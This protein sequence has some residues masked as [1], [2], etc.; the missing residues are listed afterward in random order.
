[1]KR[2]AQIV[3]RFLVG[4]LIGYVAFCVFA[5]LFPQYFYYHPLNERPSVEQARR[6]G[7]PAG[8]VEYSAADGT[9]LYGWM[10][11]P[12]SRKKMIIFLHGNSHNIGSFYYK[13]QPLAQ[14]GYGTFLPEFRGFGGINGALREA[15][16]AKDAIAAIEY[17]NKQGY[18]NSDIIVYGMSLG[19]YLASNSVYQLQKNGEFAALILEVPFD[20]L[21]NTAKAVVPIP[22]P[23]PLI[24]RDYYDNLP[25]IEDIKTPLLIM[26]AENDRTVPVHLAENLFAHANEPKK[27]II[28]PDAE[29]SNLFDSR[30]YLDILNWLQEVLY[31]KA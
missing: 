1:M 2:W 4:I 24:V 16:L 29:H 28:Y 30:N 3:K 17:L 8:E 23:L 13:L 22:L 5:Y 12:G 20:S 25:L 6:N 26:G 9:G 31:E 18:K 15:N 21:L 14:A 7:Y 19:S 27:L 11:K 10:T